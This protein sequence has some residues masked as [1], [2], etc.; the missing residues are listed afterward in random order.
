MARPK[1]ASWSQLRGSWDCRCGS[2]ASERRRGICCRLIRKSL[3]SR[4]SPENP[5]RRHRVAEESIV[6]LSGGNWRLLSSCCGWF[7]ASWETCSNPDAV[8][9][10]LAG[11]P[12]PKKRGPQNR[13]GA[14]ALAEPDE[15][16][17]NRSYPPRYL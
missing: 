4:C 13:S 5:P 15:E 14:V 8:E 12:S 2:W 16:N 1:A 9:D 11:V 17:E 6:W 10:P 3:W 7:C